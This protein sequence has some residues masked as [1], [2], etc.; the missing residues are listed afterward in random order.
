MKSKSTQ[1]LWFVCLYLA[2]ASA[3]AGIA[4]LIRF[5]LSI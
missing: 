1:W 3:V 4:Y 2:G 5:W